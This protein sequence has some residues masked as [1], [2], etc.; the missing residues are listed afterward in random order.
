MVDSA[1]GFF[2]VALLHEKSNGHPLANVEYILVRCAVRAAL[3]FEGIAVQV[4]DIDGV[5]GL[6]QA[7]AHAAE[8]GVVEIAVVGDHSHHAASVLFYLP[9]GKAQELYV[10]ILKTFGIFGSSGICVLCG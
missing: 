4:K 7:L 6:H 10:I 3:F 5:K 9:L 8:C 1:V 2:L